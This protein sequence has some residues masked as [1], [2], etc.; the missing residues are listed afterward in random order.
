MN[1]KLALFID[2]VNLYA[3]ARTLGFDIDCKPSLFDPADAFAAIKYWRFIPEFGVIVPQMGVF[4]GDLSAGF[5]PR[6]R[7][8]WARDF[9]DWP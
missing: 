3:T 8:K 2:G 5:R 7:R 1:N 6:H 4:P 9:R